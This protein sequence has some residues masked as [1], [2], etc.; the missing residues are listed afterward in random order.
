MNAPTFKRIGRVRRG[1]RPLAARSSQAEFARAV[2]V[3]QATV[4]D[5]L[6]GAALPV[7]QIARSVERLLGATPGAL[8]STPSTDL[9]RALTRAA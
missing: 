3:S 2:D 1:L 9:E 6:S 4:S 5:V 8:L 7:P